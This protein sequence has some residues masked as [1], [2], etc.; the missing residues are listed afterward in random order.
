MLIFGLGRSSTRV[1]PSVASGRYSP[2]PGT[3]ILLGDG[4]YQ[5]IRPAVANC[6]PKEPDSLATESITFAVSVQDLI[7]DLGAQ[8]PIDQIMRAVRPGHCEDF[9]AIILIARGRFPLEF[10][11]LMGG[12][13]KF[14]RGR[15][16]SVLSL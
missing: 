16:R 8:V 12:V 15:H 5:E 3:D 11:I 14:L 9:A 7:F 10:E 13:P 1:M 4:I 2:G 6:S